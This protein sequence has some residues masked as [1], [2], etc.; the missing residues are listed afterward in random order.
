MLNFGGGANRFWPHYGG[1]KM[2]GGNEAEKAWLN[3]D[4]NSYFQNVGENLM[5]GATGLGKFF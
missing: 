1:E 5:H 2:L 4:Y 3:G